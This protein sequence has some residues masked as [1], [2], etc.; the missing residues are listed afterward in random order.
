MAHAQLGT[1]LRYV[2][3]IA[4]ARS[5]ACQSDSALLRAFASHNDQ[6]AFTQLV[7]RH[8]PLVGSIAVALVGIQG[9][10]VET[11]DVASDSGETHDLGSGVELP[12]GVRKA[13][14][15]YPVPSPAAAHAPEAAWVASVENGFVW[16]TLSRVDER[17]GKVRVVWRRQGS[18][19]QYVA[20]G[21][22]SVWALIG[23]RRGSRIAR[24]TL[25]G[26]LL[27]VWRIAAA[28]RMAADRQGC[29]ISTNRWL[30]HIDPTGRVH[31]VVRGRRPPAHEPRDRPL[32]AGAAET[33]RAAEDR[34]AGPPVGSPGPVAPASL[35]RQT[36]TRSPRT[37]EAVGAPPAPGP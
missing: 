22:G 1:V 12:P 28:G 27:R 26:R 35:L 32:A 16:G 31:R 36:A 15:D 25:A 29:W 34:P 6:A 21:A 3:G 30:L 2:R 37:A 17:T 24:F 8:G 4:A 20:A 10:G 13:L 7:K 33:N 14:E 23:S 9:R 19:V 5:T 18:S 11:Y